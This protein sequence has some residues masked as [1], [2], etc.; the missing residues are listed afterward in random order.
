MIAY[1]PMVATHRVCN[2]M[3]DMRI[4][5]LRAIALT[6]STLHSRPPWKLSMFKFKSSKLVWLF[7]ASMNWPINVDG[8]VESAIKIGIY[9]KSY[10]R[11][12]QNPR[13]VGITVIWTFEGHRLVE[14][15]IICMSDRMVIWAWVAE[16]ER[17]HSFDST[18]AEL[19]YH[20]RFSLIIYQ[21][22]CNCITHVHIQTDYF[23]AWIEHSYPLCNVEK[24]IFSSSK[25]NFFFFFETGLHKLMG[26]GCINKTI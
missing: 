22:K 20:L 24:L 7:K 6:S 10:V 2:S 4:Y 5:E 21:Y 9:K 16:R 11:F 14:E 18:Y 19:N 26:H 23:H 17:E 13:L 3:R 8:S 15:V 12:K 1:A 25:T